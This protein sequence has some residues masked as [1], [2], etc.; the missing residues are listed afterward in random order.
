MIATT[1][2]SDSLALALKYYEVY[3]FLFRLD[4][5][6]VPFRIFLREFCFSVIGGVTNDFLCAV[7]YI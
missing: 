4:E 1:G 3:L 5:K 2:S 7:Y 6:A